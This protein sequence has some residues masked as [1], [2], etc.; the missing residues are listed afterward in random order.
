MHIQTLS[1]EL[2]HRAKK[3]NNKE[4]GRGGIFEMI[5]VLGHDSA[6]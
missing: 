5:G 1:Q 2:D 6:L 4:E 3:N